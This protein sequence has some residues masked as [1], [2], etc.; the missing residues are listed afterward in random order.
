MNRILCLFPEFSEYA[1]QS[2]VSLENTAFLVAFQFS[3]HNDVVVINPNKIKVFKVLLILFPGIQIIRDKKLTY[4]RNFSHIGQ[5]C[6][7]FEETG[8]NPDEVTMDDITAHYVFHFDL[9]TRY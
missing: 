6:E 9:H 8:H 4:M 7:Y 3:K 5:S 1:T 2:L